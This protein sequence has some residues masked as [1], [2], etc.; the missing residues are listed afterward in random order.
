M[1]RVHLLRL[2][3]CLTLLWFPA[4]SVATAAANLVRHDLTIHL[5][6]ENGTLQGVDHIT[7]PAPPDRFLK[8][9]LSP[10][11]SVDAVE[12][13]GA[14]LGWSFDSGRLQVG[15]LPP[16]LPADATLA[17]SYHG[18][19][20]DPVPQ[21]PLNNEDPSYGVATAITP[22]GTFL[23]GGA[24]WYPDLPGAAL[25]RV[26]ITAPAGISAVTA[27]RLVERGET[28]EG[29][30]SIWETD[31]PLPALTLAAGSWSFKAEDYGSVAIYTF[32]G[33][34]NA[35]LADAYLAAARNWLELYQ[36]RFGPYPFAKFAVVENFFPT[37]YGFPSWT[38]L[39]SSVVPLPFIVTTSLG[40]EIAHSWWGTGV[41]PDNS[42]GNWS[43]GLATYVADYLFK[44]LESTQA[45]SDYRRK[46]LRDYAT[47]VPAARDYP[48]SHFS[49]RRSKL[50]QAIGYGKSAMVFHM[51]RHL[52][53]EDA[54]WGGLRKVAR[55]RMFRQASWNDFAAAW[56]PK[57]K[58]Q[59]AEFIRQWVDRAGAPQLRLADVK[60]VRQG[61]EWI[62][63]GQLIQQGQ[64]YR[65]QL[66]LL[67]ETEAGPLTRS[68]AASGEVTPFLLRSPSQP[69]RLLIDPEADFFR[70]L[71]PSEVPA[72]VNS[73]REGR[74]LVVILADDV[75]RLVGEAAADL[76]T[77]LGREATWYREKQALAADL[78]R[79]DLLLV[80]WPRSPALRPQLPGELTINPE[81]FI[82]RGEFYPDPSAVLFAVFP[83]ERTPAL[84]CG[85]FLPLSPAGAKIAARK[86][87]HY[88]TF[89]YLAF[90]EGNNRLKGVWPV[91]SSP[92][93]HQFIPTSQEAGKP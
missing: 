40:H 90:S 68:L 47:L 60:Q 18:T 30:V 24:G 81:G 17:I 70:R 89:S 80:G 31:H 56:D 64:P 79:S 50:D 62:V 9:Q 28:P 25:F 83:R 46:L 2:F 5:N 10:L 87:P 91:T 11:V 74:D 4:T 73:L 1:K 42:Q 88:G 39:G 16:N 66:P 58:L 3:A 86:I 19:F 36:S 29:F 67:L 32:L 44:E 55:E 6:S 54:F 22:Q 12:V 76:L 14:P 48:L 8:F 53:G 43:E 13:A 49:A 57:G 41:R 69:R 35:H 26:K 72:T 37:G 38:L 15:P 92:L 21:A 84:Q 20:A 23:A 34:A 93:T 65:L 71:D 51:A 78:S 27:G 7:L 52:V 63:S 82:L 61:Q 77:G 45:A 59:L 85:L 75:D 33:P